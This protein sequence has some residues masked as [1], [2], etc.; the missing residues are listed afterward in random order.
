MYELFPGKFVS[1]KSVLKFLCNPAHK[2]TNG[3]GW[4][5]TW[6]NNLRTRCT[7][8]LLIPTA[9]GV[10]GCLKLTWTENGFANL[11]QIRNILNSTK[12]VCFTSITESVGLIQLFF[13]LVFSSTDLFRW[14]HS[15]SSTT[16]H[17]ARAKTSS[18]IFW[19][20][21]PPIAKRWHLRPPNRPHKRTK[22][23]TV[24]LYSDWL[25]HCSQWW[26]W[27]NH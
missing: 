26:W 16:Y 22:A 27:D 23:M 11:N 5:I 20:V 8:I 25:I 7:V 6:G 19:T 12:M 10:G 18:K 17:R 13:F 3:Q 4:N 21:E 15:I 1:W 9:E 14:H 24:A 2:Q